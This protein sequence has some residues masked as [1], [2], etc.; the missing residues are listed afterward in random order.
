MKLI[1]AAPIAALL[2]AC[3]MQA[4]AAQPVERTIYQRYAELRSDPQFQARMAAPA[5]R[6]GAFSWMLGEWDV[7]VTVFATP[8][9][10][11]RID[12]ERASF[13]MQGDA[14][15]VSN[16]LSTV[17]GFDAFGDR[18]F[19]AGFEPPAAPFSIGYAPSRWDGR[20]I[21][22]VNDAR[23]F[24]ETFSLRSTLTRLGPDEFELLNEERVGAGRYV[25]ADAYRYRRRSQ[26]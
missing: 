15:I 24:G 4:L 12:S 8:T 14:L 9:T 25:R 13:R 22:F 16:D 6:I 23:I 20:T 18:W 1:L 10:P 26:R 5:A 2:G 7:T 11:E 3:A 19:S 21:V 17:L